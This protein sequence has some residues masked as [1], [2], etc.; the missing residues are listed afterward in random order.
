MPSE[1][2]LAVIE[3]A[4]CAL[5]SLQPC[6]TVE[7]L[8]LGGK[9]DIARTALKALAD[10]VA[11][12]AAII[13]LPP[14]AP[15]GRTRIDMHGC[16]F[17]WPV[18]PPVLPTVHLTWAACVQRGLC[19]KICPERVITLDHRLNLAPEA[20]RPVVLYE[21]EPFAAQST[22]DRITKQLAGQHWM[23]ES[24]DRIAMLRMCDDCRVRAR[25]AKETHPMAAG[26]RS[27]TRTTDGQKQ[28]DA[29]GL[30]IEDFLRDD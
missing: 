9:R 24:D 18:C 30:S 17:A 23:F 13:P 1:Q 14:S 12:S 7:I 19:A 8:P 10:A 2:D 6:A 29:A 26:N 3:D 22:I 27:R 25:L 15:Y 5:G 28:A 21:E 4:L 16:T 11:E 20:M